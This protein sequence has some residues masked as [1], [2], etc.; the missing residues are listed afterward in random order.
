LYITACYPSMRHMQIQ[1]TIISAMHLMKNSAFKKAIHFFV[2]SRVFV[3]P[4]WP[5]TPFF[6]AN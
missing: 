6:Q 5:G 2:N 3:I 4:S 1:I